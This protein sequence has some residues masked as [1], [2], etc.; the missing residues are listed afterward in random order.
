[1]GESRMRYHYWDLIPP[2]KLPHLIGVDN[3]YHRN[4]NA[5]KE[6]LCKHN[7]KASVHRHS[8]FDK[9]FF[10]VDVSDDDN[11]RCRGDIADALDIPVDW[12]D[13]YIYN[14]GLEEYGILEDE[15]IGKY[16]DCND[17][18]HFKDEFDFMK[19]FKGSSNGY[20]ISQRLK[21]KGIC[22]NHLIAHSDSITLGTDSS[23]D[24]IS[25]ALNIPNDAVA[26]INSCGSKITH[27]IL[28]DRCKE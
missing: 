4:C 1:M 13:L 11:C 21:K 17:E 2:F 18:L 7:I 25:N 23:S 26:S 8:L 27:I 24:A 10:I 9:D 12:V 16:G 14:D 3:V 28:I 5:I 19:V 15:L 22:V 6:Q 20:N